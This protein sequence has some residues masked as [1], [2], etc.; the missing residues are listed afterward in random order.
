MRAVP[1]RAVQMLLLAGVARSV[2][3]VPAPACFGGADHSGAAHLATYGHISGA[4]SCGARRSTTPSQQQ[5]HYAELVLNTRGKGGTRGIQRWR[6]SE[7]AMVVIDMW[8]YH[9]CK[10]VT[11]RAGALVPRLNAV[12]AAVRAA[13]GLV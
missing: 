12:A 8:S 13:G 2:P 7:T 4:D 9:P 6:G 11:N 3:F 1:M 5:D 10:T